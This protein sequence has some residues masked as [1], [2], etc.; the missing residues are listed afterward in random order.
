MPLGSLRNLLPVRGRDYVTAVRSRA[1]LACHP[2]TRKLTSPGFGFPLE[3]DDRHI[4]MAISWFDWATAASPDGGVPHSVNL[5]NFASDKPAEIAPS[6]PETSGYILCTLI[7]GLRSGLPSLSRARLEGLCQYLMRAQTS[8][9]GMPGPGQDSRCLSFDTGQVLTG[10]TSFHRHIDQSAELRSVIERAADWMSAQVEADGGFSPISCYRGQRV[11]YVQATIGLLHAARCFGRND[12][13]DAAARNADWAYRRHCGNGWFETISF[14]DDDYQNLHGIAYTLRG[15]IELGYHLRRPEMIDAGR[16]AIDAMAGRE[17][18]GLPAPNALP[19]HFARGYDEYHR[20]ISPT[21]MSQIAICAYMLAQITADTKYAQL[22]DRLTEATKT[23][24]L[25]GFSTPSL[26]GAL[27][28]SWPV[29]GPYMH[30]S[31]PNWPLKFFL[32]ALYIK[33]GADPMRIEG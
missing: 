8:S 19:G 4:A 2:E 12:W 9:G 13:L 1:I 22:G 28:G 32:D 7:Y 17:Y 23:F 29:T 18:R 3:S 10:L 11:Y 21:G 16:A 15:M 6:Y 14:E 33:S 30:A 26:N 5:R 24:Q 20:S 25:R 27:P 31:L